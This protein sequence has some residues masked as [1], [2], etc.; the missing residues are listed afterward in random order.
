TGS[1][2]GQGL[3]SSSGI[4]AAQDITATRD[5]TASR[6]MLASGTITGTGITSTQ[7]VNAQQDVIATRD[8]TAGRNV[9]TTTGEVKG[10][11]VTA[12]GVV[13][14][15]S[16]GV[17][18]NAPGQAVEILRD[19]ADVGLR[20]HDPNDWWYTMGIDRSAQKFVIN[21][22]GN[23]GDNNDFAIDYAG[24]VGIGTSSPDPAA[25]L[26]VQGRVK[27]ADGSQGAGKVLTSDASGLAGWAL[28]SSGG[29]VGASVLTYGSSGVPP[30]CPAGWSDA[31]Y[32]W[33]ITAGDRIA[34]WG[35]FFRTCYR[36][37]KACQ[38]LL[39]GQ[40]LTCPAGWSQASTWYNY[41]AGDRGGAQGTQLT[42]CFYCPP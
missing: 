5:I 40:T 7:N 18:T 9:V 22:G 13:S 23:L 17:G 12:T 20:F 33:Q 36:T 14:G 8:I 39:V 21:R 16:L 1:L 42:S 19:N 2:T 4:T 26:D 30:N 38:S 25:K 41:G 37:D 28:P 34:A 32:W 11:T 31:G 6:N 24:N 27:I 29:G 35:N 10:N 3:A 15:A